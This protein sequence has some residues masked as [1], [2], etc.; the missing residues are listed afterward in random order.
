MVF[1]GADPG[2]VGRWRWRRPAL[3]FYPFAHGQYLQVH[4]NDA[5]RDAEALATHVES[6]QNRG[7]AGKRSK[8]CSPPRP[9]NWVCSFR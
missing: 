4:L 5:V 7:G 6:V 8:G 3:I 9:R 1:R 2:G